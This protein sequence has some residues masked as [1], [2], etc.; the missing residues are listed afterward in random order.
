MK[1]L[2]LLLQVNKLQKEINSE[3]EHR[4]ELALMEKAASDV[5]HKNQIRASIE[6]S[7]EK[8]QSLALLMLHYCTGLQH[9]MDQLEDDATEQAEEAEPDSA[10]IPSQDAESVVSAA[11][12]AL[13]ASPANLRK[14][15]SAIP[16]LCVSEH[17]DG[18]A[19]D[20]A[21]GTLTSSNNSDDTNTA[22]TTLGMSETGTSNSSVASTSSV[23]STNGTSGISSTVSTSS[24]PSDTKAPDMDRSNLRGSMENLV[25]A[26]EDAALP[27]STK[28]DIPAL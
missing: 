26:E 11:S 23:S 18:S 1:T 4:S 3:A 14:V 15:Q 17:Q 24:V 9:C 25:P 13:S 5:T 7:D 12:T 21:S 10:S 8:I 6:K 19:T 28:T 20:V 27:Q 2:N 16:V 22:S